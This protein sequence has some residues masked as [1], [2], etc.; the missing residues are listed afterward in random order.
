M[1]LIRSVAFW[2]PA[3][4]TFACSTY[5]TAHPQSTTRSSADNVISSP[6]YRNSSTTPARAYGTDE[7]LV[8][9]VRAA[10]SQDPTLRS[11][12]PEIQ[13]TA[14]NGMI[15]LNGSVPNPEL[16]SSLLSL[17]RNTPGVTGVTDQL[18]M[19]STAPAAPVYYPP[20]QVTPG[21]AVGGASTVEQ[22]SQSK[23]LTGGSAI[24]GQ[25]F[26]MQVDSLTDTDR[27]LA[28][29]I[30]QGLQTDTA[31]A[32]MLPHVVINV[33]QGRVLLQGTVQ[34]EAQRQTIGDA[35]RRAT[36]GENVQNQLQVRAP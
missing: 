36:G 18:F 10:L 8:S 27:N 19:P 31:L 21:P 12:A 9:A 7:Q 30:L 3:L 35:V 28:Q 24:S 33:S 4:L 22:T 15:T 20:P 6:I 11:V 5:D 26:S 13:V 17:V 23:A 34:S 1:R 14:N 29:R 32:Q 16:R 2:T 25:I